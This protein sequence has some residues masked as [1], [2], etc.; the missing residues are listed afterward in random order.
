MNIKLIIFIFLSNYIKVL[1]SIFFLKPKILIAPVE[2]AGYYKRLNEGLRTL[3]QRSDFLTISPNGFKYGGET[4]KPFLL[5]WQNYV[6]ENYST[7]YKHIRYLR[8]LIWYI[9]R[10][11]GRMH[12]LWLYWLLIRY[13][14][15]IF[16]FGES[17]F[18]DHRD[19]K[20]LQRLNKRVICN[21]A[22]GSEARPTF[23]DGAR[24][25]DGGEFQS[26]S[27][28]LNENK[29][30]RSNVNYLE[31]NTSIILCFPYTSQF[32]KK[33]C[34]NSFLLGI[35]ISLNT[36][37][38]TGHAP[39]LNEDSVRILHSPSHKGVKG[40]DVIVSA[41]QNLKEKGY[42]IEFIQISGK[43]NAE[44]LKELQLCD[45]VIDQIFSETPMA[46]FATEA[47]FFG[48]AAI[49]GG[50]DWL[51]LKE[52]VPEDLW[53]PSKLCHPD[54]I[55]VCIEELILN[56]VEREELGRKA[57]QFVMEK[58]SS[59]EVAKRFLRIINDDIPQNWFYDPLEVS[60]LYG[61]GQPLNRT[62]HV[63]SEVIEKH[64][65]DSMGFDHRPDL[66]KKY[67]HLLED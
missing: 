47:A 66:I 26:I 55:Q 40:T 27:N 25:P 32:L 34:I 24:H 22:H 4:V 1:K 39:R 43:P 46:G 29:L 67:L 20:I 36:S 48:K 38:V 11:L 63:I 61:G 59:V 21:I 57:Q 62:K 16:S 8:G 15:F 5:R 44:V 30:I 60:Y 65:V 51:T 64:G 18:V 13:D 49:V 19:L 33:R 37:Q 56:K 31:Q 54:E 50:Y 14:V 45:F 52:Y 9:Q 35:P 2:I 12:V 17:L 7:R 28:L 23:L 53:P 3:G 41:I 6:I 10:Y 42:K 58:W